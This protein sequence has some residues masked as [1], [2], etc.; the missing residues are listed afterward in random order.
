MSNDKKTMLGIWG[1]LVFT[2]SMLFSSGNMAGNENLP[3]DQLTLTE[4][5]CQYLVQAGIGIAVKNGICS[6]DVKYRKN[7][8]ND[9]GTIEHTNG[10]PIE[11]SAGQVVAVREID[12]GSKDPWT[13]RQWL[14]LVWFAGSAL[15]AVGSACL[16]NGKSSTSKKGEA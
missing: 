8:L 7:R 3:T 11:I 2:L 6:I 1:T 10:Q 9:G 16:I 14:A 5:A 13:L 12:D 4:P 15:A